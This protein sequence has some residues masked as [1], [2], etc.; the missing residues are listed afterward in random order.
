LKSFGSGFFDSTLAARKGNGESGP[1][2]QEAVDMW[3]KK[4]SLGRTPCSVMQTGF[5]SQHWGN[6]AR[7]KY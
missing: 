2:Y 7:K 1:F 3:I 5:K 6:F 4:P